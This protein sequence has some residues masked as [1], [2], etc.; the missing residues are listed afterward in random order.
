MLIT[1]V[2]LIV[3]I[4][5]LLIGNI[6]LSIAS[7]SE[8]SKKEDIVAA[9]ARADEFI[10]SAPSK[11]T[12]SI[13]NSKDFKPVVGRSELIE[14]RLEQENIFGKVQMLSDFRQ[15]IKI[16]V[17]ALDERLASIEERLSLKKKPVQETD[18]SKEDEQLQ[19]K[20]HNL[21]YH[22]GKAH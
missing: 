19:K 3:L 13:S 5:A 4:I 21:V 7:G 2:F 12:H 15:E 14:K 17:A 16:E 1:T 20:I 18:F 6:L 22:A 8:P 11:Q 10:A 9:R